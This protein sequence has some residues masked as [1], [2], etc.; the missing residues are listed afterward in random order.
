MKVRIAECSRQLGM[1]I[2][3]LSLNVMFC[4]SYESVGR[5]ERVQL[6]ESQRTGGWRWWKKFEG[7]GK[8]ADLL[9]R[10]GAGSITR[11]VMS[12]VTDSPK[13]SK[14]KSSKEKKP[15][16]KSQNERL[17]IV[18][19]RLPPN[20]PEDIFWQS[21][22]EWV[23]DATVSWKSFHA[24]KVKKRWVFLPLGA[25]IS[26][27]GIWL[28]RGGRLNKETIPSRA[29]LAFKTEEQLA[30][31]SRSFDGH[32]FRDKA[33]TCRPRGCA[34]AVLT[35]HVGNEAQVV[36]EF[37]PYQKVPTE[38]SK[39]DNRIATIEEGTPHSIPVPCR[40]IYVNAL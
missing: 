13:K 11:T 16:G 9:S 27:I 1:P 7:R 37:S 39:A 26:C 5:G 31:F 10:T 33:G 14:P 40:T 32:I 2:G 35:F 23:S 18:V 19:R 36:L 17:K 22:S 3:L 12:A 8:I 34:I 29:Y 24:G 28:K 21:V 15:Q 30:L 38:K 6:T 25:T 4:S 20:L